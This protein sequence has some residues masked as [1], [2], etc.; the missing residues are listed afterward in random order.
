MNGQVSTEEAV[1]RVDR[2]VPMLGLDIRR[3]LV[4]RAYLQASNGQV[5]TDL[6][7]VETQ[8]ADG[9]AQTQNA[10]RIMLA[11]ELARVLDVGNRPIEKQDKA[12]LP[13]LAHY[14]DRADVRNELVGRTG[15]QERKAL[16]IASLDSF[17][18]R[19]RRATE[20]SAA[21]ENE[22]SAILKLRSFRDY[23]IAHSI[24]DKQPKYPKYVDLFRLCSMAAGLAHRAEIATSG[25]ETDFPLNARVYRQ[26]A[27]TYWGAFAVGVRVIDQEVQRLRS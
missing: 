22:G 9:H 5:R 18:K 19:W 25:D 24:F 11:I 23:E 15:H 16:I 13:V 21:E 6:A 3:A 17:L 8:A 4:S 26:Q 14:F 12:S 2:I 10:H 20:E 1:R 7:G 27:E